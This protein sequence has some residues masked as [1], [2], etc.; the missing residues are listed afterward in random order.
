MLAGILDLVPDTAPALL[1]PSFHSGIWF[2][3]LVFTV[4]LLGAV[5]I[6]TPVPENSLLFLAGA[7]AVNNQ[8]SLAWVLAASVAGA[9]VGYDLNYWTGR[10]FSLAVCRR[11]CPHIL[12]TR[13]MEKARALLSR[14]GPLSVVISRFIPAVN[15]PPFF[16]GLDTMDYGRYMVA[17]LSGAVLWCGITVLLGYYVGSFEIIQDYVAS[18]FDIVLIVT[19]ITIAYAV[20]QLARARMAGKETPA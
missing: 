20:I 18:I 2:Y 10:I 5:F 7:M 15:L 9:Y 4:I 13:N 12:R 11:F 6:I 17:N 14:F 19:A 1:G 16:A 3:L 8:V